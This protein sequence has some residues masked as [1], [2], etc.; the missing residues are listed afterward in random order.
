M[1][2]ALQVEALSAN[3]TAKLDHVKTDLV[4]MS[5]KYNE[6]QK[7]SGAMRVNL[8]SLDILW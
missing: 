8:G 3:F 1:P 4:A 7:T 2:C 6:S 5:N